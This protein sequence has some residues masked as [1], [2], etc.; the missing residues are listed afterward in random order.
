MTQEST[1][2]PLCDVIILTALPAE[3]RAVYHYLQEPQEHVHPSGT[4]Y[5][6][7]T[8]S[9]K[10]RIWHVAAAQVGTG[11]VLAAVAA[12]RAISF[13]HTPQIALFVGTAGG[14][15]DVRRGDVVVATKIY[16]YESGKDGHAF[17]PRPELWRTSHALEQRARQEASGEAWL[18]LLGGTQLPSVPRVHLG[19]LAAG[20]KTLTSTQETTAALL[21]S[22]YGDALAVEREGHGF[23]Q[24]VHLNHAVHGLVVRGIA[25]LIDEK[26][27]ADATGWQQVAAEHAAAFAFQVLAT[28]TLPEEERR[29]SPV[30]QQYPLPPGSSAAHGHPDIQG[31]EQISEISGEKRRTFFENCWKHWRI[32]LVFIVLLLLLIRA[33]SLGIST[34]R[35]KGN[36]SLK[37]DPSRTWL[38]Q[39]SGI[40]AGLNS[41]AWCGSQFVTVGWFGAILTSSDGI[42]WTPHTSGTS[43]VAFGIACSHSQFVAVGESGTMFTSRDGITWT[44]LTPRTSQ[45]LRGII[46]SGSQ[47]VAVG[48]N[49]T[50]LTSHDAISWTSH[51]SG[52]SQSLQALARCGSQFVIV[53]LN[54]T[55]LTS[56]D[57]TSWTPH[58][59]GT[60]QHLRRIACAGSQFVAV[61][62]GGTIL[63]SPNG[64]S[65]TSRTSRTSPGLL[66]V[67]SSGS[68]LVVVGESGTI[69]TSS[70]GI[71][72][73]SHPFATPRDL[74]GVAWSGSR[75]VAVGES[76]TI[77]TLP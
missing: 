29:P 51:P 23:L 59:S 17:E 72:W 40:T 5:F 9:G 73:A 11:G 63:T 54:G 60:L 15:K 50:I 75:F 71:S 25:N 21:A 55:I 31:G 4:I 70:D 68:L 77:L 66:G 14:R 16:A 38:L 7:G 34:I 61:G 45:Y 44:S 27:A 64:I 18:S 62:D 37:V 46:W 1:T 35:S 20:D 33:S 67:T 32:A 52:T 65:W 47:F 2:A 30:Q 6:S 10:H 58:P 39:T 12:E 49:G 41:I 53:G 19:P 26:A 36:T 48:D 3:Y 69:L 8:F 42:S 57:G 13:L 76:G 56:L 24:A 43:H 74:R 22:T 28:L